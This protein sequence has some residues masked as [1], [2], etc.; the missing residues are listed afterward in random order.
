MPQA[1]GKNV[2]LTTLNVMTHH[3]NDKL[4]HIILCRWKQDQCRIVGPLYGLAISHGSD[5]IVFITSLI[6]SA[7]LANYYL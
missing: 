2:Q 3:L 5:K 4:W 6:L 1:A 7:V